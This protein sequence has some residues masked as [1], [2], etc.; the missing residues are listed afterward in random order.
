AP[1]RIVLAVD[2]TAEARAT[3]AW[4]ATTAGQLDAAVTAVCPYRRP[5][6]VPSDAA[7]QDFRRVQRALHDDW[8]APLRA[9]GIETHVELT[10]APNLY[11]ALTDAAKRTDA[12]LIV[13]SAEGE[14][15]HS[16]DAAT[17]LMHDV[18]VP[19]I[20]VPSPLNEPQP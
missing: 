5:R 13:S 12:G 11:C 8:T 17:R 19:I 3:V 2:G 1:R 15:E 7:H 4:C 16:G 14:P 18:H 10:H 9:A 20:L 6:D